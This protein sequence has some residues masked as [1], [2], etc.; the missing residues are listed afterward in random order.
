MRAVLDEGAHVLFIVPTKRLLQNLIEDAREQ[1]RAQ[2]RQRGLQDA[3]IRAWIDERITEWSGNQTQGRLRE[4]RGD[5]GSPTP[6]MAADAAGGRVIFAIPEVVV[7][8]IS[9]IAITGASVVNPFLYPRRFDHIVF[10]EFHTIDDRSFGSCACS[11][12]WP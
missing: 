2:L 7:G 10:D 11:R 4:P 6:R 12:C 8:M 9:G 3:Q 5:S 1:A